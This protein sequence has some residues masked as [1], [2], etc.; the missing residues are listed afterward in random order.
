MATSEGTQAE[1]GQLIADEFGVNADYVSE[2]LS[3]FERDRSSV[4]DDWRSFFDELLSNGRS[5]TETE[6]GPRAVEP[7]PEERAQTASIRVA[8]GAIQATYEWGR[9]AEAPARKSA[10]ETVAPAP[11]TQPQAAI[12]AAEAEAVERIPIR[13]PA[14][15]I[16][17]NM[18]A[19]LAV[20][21][22]TSQRQVP[23][24]LLD[25]NRQVINKHLA[26]SGRK[27]SYTHVAA[28][29]ILKVLES[30][31]QLNDSF[32]EQDESA[33]R[34]RHQQVNFGVAVDVTKKDGTR[35]LLVP[36]IKGA[37]KLT[38]SQLLDAYDDV[39]KRARTGKL[40]ISDFQGT[41]ISLTN[42]GTIGTTASNPRLMSG[43]GVIV[44]TGA[45]GY[46]PEYQAMS[47]EGL[48][49]IGISKVMTITSTYDHRIVQGAESG[50]FLA[51]IDELLRGQHE[52]YDQI[53]AD[54]GIRYRPYRWAMDVNPAILGE[55]RRRDV[56]RKQARV[57][58]LIN[59]YRVRG[60]LIA[61]LDPLGCKT[62]Q[63][64][65]ELDIETYGLTI[66]D[67]DR[68][69]ITGGVGGSETATLR[70]IVDQLH[71]YYCGKVGIEY[72]NIQGPEE[73][74]WIRARVETEPPPVPA[75]VKKQI[76]WKLISAELFERF[77]GTKYLGQKRFSIE[78]N[79]TVIA[80]LDQLIDSAAPRG[81][82]D[83]TIGMAHRG[84]LNVIANVIG[85]FCERIFTSF[86]GSIHPNFPHDQGDVKYHQ[87]ASGVRE[88]T[89]GREVSLVVVPNPSH[90]EFVDPVVEGM[91]RA[92][93]D[94]DGDRL[95]RLAVLLHGDA[96]FAGEGIV[97]ETLNLSQLPGYKTGGTI[98][99]ITN[100]QLGFTTP[101]EEG[102]SSTYST[103]IAK[104]IQAPV[105][106]V[107][108]DDVEAAYNVLQIALD[109]RQKF[110][111]DVVIDV[112]GFRRLG[113][114]E[115]DEP[116]YTQ[117]VMY[118]RIRKHPGARALYAKK[119]AAEGV[120]TEEVIATLMDERN[121]RYENA[122][123]GAK[124]IVA[125]QDT[126][127][128]LPD[129]QPEPETVDVIATGVEQE[130]LRRIAHAI[131]T[132]PRGFNLNPKIVGLLARRA[133]MVEGAAAVDWGMAE[134]LAF[135]SLLIEGTPVRLSGQD[136]VRG[137]FSH[138]HAAFTDTQT[139]VE[140]APLAQLADGAKYEIYDSPLSEAGALGFE[141]GYSVAAP[142]T[143]VLWEAQF[144]DFINAAQVIVD[145]FIA[146]G[147]EKWNQPTGIVLLLPH[148]YEGQGSEHSSARIERFL[149]LCADGNMQ[150]V[151][152]T[153]AAQ[154]FHVLRRQAQQR[155]RK[156]LVIITPKSLLRLPDAASPVEQFSR[157]GFLPVIGDDSVAAASVTRVLLCSGKV[158]YDLV[159]ERR[160]VGESGIAIVRVE[161]FYP[162]PKN[163]L[164]K[165]LSRFPN[166]ADVRWVQ[167]EPQ[168]MGEW[169]FMEPR[170]LKMLGA[171]RTLRY[172][173]RPPSASPATGSHTIHQMEQQ[174]LV[175]QA[176]SGD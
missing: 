59:A 153:T 174:Q 49:R 78:G 24:K 75:E 158:Y 166:A 58:E 56:V 146:S 164:V 50:A 70:E 119:L 67:L 113:H 108:S 2:L 167:E 155:P 132:V 81:I 97:A 33:Y 141:Y 72:R 131:T 14:L 140:W 138:R 13:G 149:Q 84:R 118:Q 20:P 161:Q 152:C 120:M 87:G 39:I 8:P 154:Y 99:I 62:V 16:A 41:T 48:S 93:Q 109:Y 76:L 116:T 110:Q 176:F 88:T 162:F 123:L 96:A 130:T 68:Q 27:V 127:I 114:N 79:E 71:D 103:D 122:Q 29:A 160:K 92:R 45:I 30:F 175:K 147:E 11:A 100:N 112:I 64:H 36:N 106:H 133:K 139:G 53:F 66:W 89:D 61:D 37:D 129:H 7:A 136:T 98:H 135:G 42:P 170:L 40:Q 83:I 91:V 47:P 60:H 173:G 46:P 18:E 31:P 145:Q 35:T 117:P 80:V 159:A 144:G 148:G 15:R 21:T 38:F 65:P 128:A 107:N 156:P 82:D 101:P 5:V 22:A 26:A 104:M 23:L 172:I 95:S 143:L 51:L 32:E 44:A 115:G 54:L 57:F 125:K 163:L 150:V 126:Q 52:F 10:Q 73:K 77:L 121:R 55:E 157:G 12:V 165:E 3:Q 19:S 63:Y 124:A 142:D 1:I 4:D 86:E 43:Q 90:L 111:R 134:A 169:T 105:F 69:F 25:E 74:E 94:V 28:R 168:N 17:E 151:N 9:E 137:T 85:K 6:P 171:A 34:L 102:R